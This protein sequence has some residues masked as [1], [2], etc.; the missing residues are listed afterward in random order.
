MP[1]THED[2]SVSFRPPADD[3]ADFV[4]DGGYLKER[5]VEAVLTFAA[6]LKGVYTILRSSQSGTT[7][8]E[9]KSGRFKSHHGK[10]RSKDKRRIKRA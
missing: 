4:V 5:V 7:V 9:E 8:V 10:R 1:H 3:D 2:R 6:P